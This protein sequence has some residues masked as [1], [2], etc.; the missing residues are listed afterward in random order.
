MAALVILIGALVGVLFGRAEAHEV[1]WRQ[2]IGDDQ[3]IEHAQSLIYRLGIILLLLLPFIPG[4]ELR[5]LSVAM[6]V[7][8]AS[9][10]SV[11]RIAFNV[12]TRRIGVS[13]IR[14]WWYMGP[15]RR[16]L[17]DSLYDTLWWII[18]ARTI[19]PHTEDT[20]A[21]YVLVRP[22]CLPAPWMAAQT[23]EVLVIAIGCGWM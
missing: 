15:C 22:R 16:R 8:A 12:W 5:T 21:A 4:G 7:A 20:G 6:V 14:Q 18:T 3:N 23:F 1:R 11:H 2:R 13:Q 19:S 17:R 9:C 10:A